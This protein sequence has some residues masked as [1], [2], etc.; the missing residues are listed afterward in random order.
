MTEEQRREVSDFYF[1]HYRTHF[2]VWPQLADALASI[3]QARRPAARAACFPPGRA[4][5][6]SLY[7]PGLAMLVTS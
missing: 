6:D 2:R 4:Q 3:P 5:T 7:T 1:N